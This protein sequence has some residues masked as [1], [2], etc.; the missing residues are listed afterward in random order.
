MTNEQR[1]RE[2][3]KR[4]TVELGE[5]RER[6]H[7]FRY[8]PI[9]IVGMSCRYPGGA[10]SPDRLWDLVAAGQ[11]A[12]SEFPADRGWDLAGLCNPDPTASGASHAREG[13]FLYDVADFD[14]AFFGIAP[15]EALALDPQQRLLLEVCW[16]TLEVAGLDPSSLRGTSTGVFVGVNSSD[17]VF[18]L[19]LSDETLDGYRTLSVAPSIVS[20][21]VAYALGLEGPTMTVDTA[22]SSS[23]VAI[24]LAVQAL[25]AEECS[26]ALAGGVT[27]LATA[28]P[29]TEFSAQRGV[30]P[31]A[32]CKSFAEAADGV[33]WAEGV[34]VLGLERLSD[35][36][37]NGHRV[38]GLVRGSAIN[39]DGASNGMTAPNGPSQERLI[40]QALANARLQ[41][42]DVDAVEAHGTGTTLGDPIEAGALLATYGQDRETP[43][44]LGSIKSNIGH[45]QA[46]AGVAGV[47][48][49]VMAMREGVLPKTLHVDRPSS[50]IDWEAGEIEL[51]TEPVEWKANGRPRRAGVSAFGMSGTNAHL[52]LEEAPAPAGVK[53]QEQELLPGPV[54][55]VLSAKSPQAL[56][57]SASRLA[58]HLEDNPELDLTDFAFSLATTRAA[59]QERAAAVGEERE[60]MLEALDAV[61]AG[62]PSS[63]ARTATARS[64]RLAYL[65]TGQGSQRAQMGKELYE[66]HPV[67]REVLDEACAEID[68]H[69]DRSLKELLF[70]EPG[71]KQAGLLDGTAY[72]QPAFFATEAALYRTLASFGLTPDFL[73]GHSV[74]EIV[75]AHV[76]GVLDLKDAAKLVCA[77]GR[78]MGELPAGGA[79]LAIEA[80]EQ[81]TMEAI[82]GKEELLS[83]AA[84]NGP[85]ATVISGDAEEIEKQEADWQ[86][87]GKKSKRL[88]VSHAFHSPLVEPMLEEF[89][90][91]IADLS[92]AGPKIPI[93]SNTSGELLSAERA[94]DPAYWVSHARQPVR[95]ADAVATLKEKD[96]TVYMEIGPKAVLTAM[97]ASCLAAEDRAELIPTLREGRDEAKSLALAFASAVAA[98]AKPDWSVF[99]EGTGAKAVPLPTYPFQRKRYWLNAS[100]GRSDPSAIG[101]APAEHPFL[102][103]KIEDPQ[104]EGLTLTGRVSLQSHAWLA[105]HVVAGS[106]LLPGVAF[107]EMALKAGREVGCE[108]LEELTLQAPLILPESGGVALQV[109][110]E[111]A[112]KRGEREVSIH[113]RPETSEEDEQA[114]WTCHGRGVLS[115][116]YPTQRSHSRSGPPRVPSRSTS[117]RPTSVSPRSGSTTGPP[118]RVSPPPGGSAKRSTRRWR[119]PR[120][121]HLRQSASRSTRRC[122]T[123]PSRVDFSR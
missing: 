96:T 17:Y 92:F 18:G 40:R 19:S 118:S 27:V 41:A 109:R 91:Q 23:L 12:I 93:V 31:D 104:G 86:D 15:R 83:L 16:E 21:R 85:A 123:Q 34:G 44:K 88:A 82:A 3:L 7:A 120:S 80:T 13:G 72:A 28:I 108:L 121:R 38:L 26:L 58:A 89:A 59:M 64:G 42:K 4:V 6:L 32:R 37:R 73:T 43:L 65:F 111:G 48:K 60:E 69:L 54:P 75:A 66:T 114:E 29:F 62:K 1:L 20:G 5:E 98:G 77:R 115:A 56:R 119:L 14:P 117:T 49:T 95:F 101:Q 71:S 106:V 53:E 46:A 90:K 76:S 33:G 68:R 74:G 50:K 25:R 105:D 84:I 99:F 100:T 10:V 78:L 67:Y 35:A 8:E 22:C 11:D 39:Q 51:L 113:S 107:V 61:A 122:S 57:E 52:I 103:A 79:M 97:A 2:Y 116:A 81:E 47:I 70:A 24:H 110:V 9:A 45:A 87:K 55:L 112:G 36:E 102:A 30:A 63:N 94:T